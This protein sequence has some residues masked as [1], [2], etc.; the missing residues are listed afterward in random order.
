[1]CLTPASPDSKLYLKAAKYQCAVSAWSIPGMRK[2]PSEKMMV[3]FHQYVSSV[4]SFFFKFLL[5]GKIMCLHFAFNYLSSCE[6]I[7][8]SQEVKGCEE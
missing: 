7:T 6:F 2:A 3:C 1:M 5:F 8:Q 4:F